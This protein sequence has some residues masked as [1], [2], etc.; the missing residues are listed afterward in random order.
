MATTRQIVVIFSKLRIIQR[1]KDFK[2][3]NEA[4]LRHSEHY[5]LPIEQY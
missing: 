1:I 5:F 4:V 3:R 2:K